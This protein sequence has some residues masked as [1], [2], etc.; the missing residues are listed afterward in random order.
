MKLKICARCNKPLLITSF[1]KNK[2]TK[3]NL[4][5]WCLICCKE[6]NSSRYF[7]TKP[8]HLI[9]VRNWQK[10]NK[11]KTSQYKRNWRQR[12]KFKAAGVEIPKELL[13]SEL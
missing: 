6:Y 10:E 12:M 5:S 7:R 11:E 9:K 1:G 3:D 8:E 2:H 4:K 13:N